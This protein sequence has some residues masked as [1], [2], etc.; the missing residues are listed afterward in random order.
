MFSGYPEF[1]LDMHK[2]DMNY[3]TIQGKIYFISLHPRKFKMNGFINL[4]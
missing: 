2:V 1:T 4:V 3:N